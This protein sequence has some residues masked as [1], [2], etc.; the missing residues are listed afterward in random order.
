M[1]DLTAPGDQEIRSLSASQAWEES[2]PD[3]VD[4]VERAVRS[5]LSAD[6]VQQCSTANHYKELYV[7][8]PVGST[9]IEGYVDLLVETP[10]GLVVVDYK[11]DLITSVAEVDA[12]LA[13]Y[14]L[15]GAAYAIAIEK[16]TG[17]SVIDVQFVFTRPE[18]P[19]VRSIEDL[20]SKRTAILTTIGAAGA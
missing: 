19:I 13:H 7:A 11:T 3:H 10:T 9:T 14:A 1:L 2:I 20:A 4:T 6:I 8:S 18:G 5:A 17:L 16:A 12:K 15:Q